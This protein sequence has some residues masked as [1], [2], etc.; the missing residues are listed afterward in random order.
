MDL[1]HCLD[2]THPERQSDWPGSFTRPTATSD[3][4]TA[5]L[6]DDPYHLYSNVI[7]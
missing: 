6:R 4:L 5:P 3:D 2:L 1:R 7:Q